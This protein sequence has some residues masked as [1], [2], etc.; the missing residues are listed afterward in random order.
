MTIEGLQVSRN[1]HFVSP[2]SGVHHAAVI[3][4]I[5]D[6]GVGSVDLYVFPCRDFAGMLMPHVWYSE[7]GSEPGTWHWPEQ[8]RK[9]C[10]P[11]FDK[12]D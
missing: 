7:G 4:D 5:R 1:V 8:V 10:D 9:V 12:V 3:T 11:D 2:Q 6:A